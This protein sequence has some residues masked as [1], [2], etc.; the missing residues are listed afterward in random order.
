M[1]VALR[2]Y[3][4]RQEAETA[5]KELRRAGFRGWSMS[6]LFSD[7]RDSREFAK[8]METR[9][10]AGTVDSPSATVPLEGDTG[11]NAPFRG[12]V[13][14]ALD[15]ALQEID[16]PADWSDR[17]RIIDGEV[18]FSVQCDDGEALNRAIQILTAIGGHEVSFHRDAA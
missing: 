3:P 17:K 16:I 5:V 2:F 13:R 12:P 7:N 15:I 4:S 11:L 10:P 1:N 8:E 18:L 14:G 9:P 6:A